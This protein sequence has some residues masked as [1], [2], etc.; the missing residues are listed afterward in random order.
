MLAA[1]NGCRRFVHRHVKKKIRE[2]GLNNA[3]DHNVEVS[4]QQLVEAATRGD[5][6]SRRRL[7]ERFREP[8]YQSAFRVTGRH[9]DALDVVQDA[10][11][12]AFDRLAE[13][14]R[15]SG[16][17]T[18]LLRIVTNRSLDVLRAR[19]VRLAAPLEAG[20]EE[21]RIEPPSPADQSDPARGAEQAELAARLQAAID[22]LPPDQRT[23][24]ALFATGGLSYGEIA[25]AVGI[26]I[27]TVMSRL[28]HARKKLH[29]LLA[30][31]AP[32]EVKKTG[33]QAV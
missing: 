13:F 26:P 14:Q 30:D 31:L 12:R 32:A 10:F 19:K 28:F 20:D 8:A 6:E 18:W 7:F 22:T 24:F 11:I 1:G 3:A 25:E 2:S 17:K 23:V 27:G 15:E 21:G 5:R 4:D 33:G 29:E 9:E 16:F